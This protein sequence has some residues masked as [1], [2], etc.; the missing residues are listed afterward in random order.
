MATMDGAGQICRIVG[1]EPDERRER[2]HID[3]IKSLQ[4]FVL[5]MTPVHETAQWS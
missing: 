4:I 3:F 2:K 1:F 5:E